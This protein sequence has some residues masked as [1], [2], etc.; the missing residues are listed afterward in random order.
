MLHHFNE[1]SRLL[2]SYGLTKNSAAFFLQQVALHVTAEDMQI[3]SF[4]PGQI[5][6]DA[7]R[8]AGYDETSGIDWDDGR[9]TDSATFFVA[10]ICV[11][12][13]LCYR[14]SSWSVCRLGRQFGG[15]TVTWSFCLGELGC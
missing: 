15:G 9:E 3:V 12:T 13:S 7:A 10:I 1:P 5:L 6:T 4:N 14:E 8:N 2:P 11:L